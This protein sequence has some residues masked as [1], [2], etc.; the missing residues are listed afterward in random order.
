[1]PRSFSG[2]EFL[3]ALASDAVR[4]RVAVVGM[5]KKSEEASDSLQFAPGTTCEDW[6][7]IPVGLIDRV[8]LLRQVPCD[9]HTH[10]LVQLTLKESDS[11]E[12]GVLAALLGHYA[13]IAA[14]SAPSPSPCTPPAHAAPP[15]PQGPPPRARPRPHGPTPHGPGPQTSPPP[16]LTWGVTPDATPPQ[17][18]PRLQAECVDGSSACVSD[19]AGGFTCLACCHGYWNNIGPCLYGK[20]FGCNGVNYNAYNCWPIG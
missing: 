17:T 15:V 11:P 13:R 18:S 6:T 9:D 5:V 4:D 8:D 20:W 16:P 19:G 14:T 7:T 12:Y 1:M 3:Q 10:S 2:E